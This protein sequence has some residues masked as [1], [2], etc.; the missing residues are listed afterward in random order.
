MQ[1]RR[2]LCGMWRIARRLFLFILLGYFFVL[3]KT[4]WVFYAYDL[5]AFKNRKTKDLESF[6]WEEMVGCGREKAYTGLIDEGIPLDEVRDKKGDT[7]L[8]FAAARWD[9]ESCQWLVEHGMDP[10]VKND[11]GWTPM[12]KSPWRDAESYLYLAECGGRHSW[13]FR[14][15]FQIFDMEW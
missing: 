1:V 3:F 11:L 13:K 5:S 12:D 14:F 10:N 4:L 7:L 8:H 9:L 6:Y 15:W 2:L